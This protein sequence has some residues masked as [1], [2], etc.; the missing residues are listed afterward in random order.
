MHR[1]G[2]KL[3][4][5]RP[6]PLA[7]RYQCRRR[8]FLQQLQN[9]GLLPRHRLRDRQEVVW[10]GHHR[11]V[12]EVHQ[13]TELFLCERRFE[14]TAPGDDGEVV[15]TGACEDVEDGGGDVG[16]GEKGDE[17][18]GDVRRD[19]SVADDGHLERSY[20]GEGVPVDEGEGRDAVR[21][22]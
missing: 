14:G 5:P 1:G 21:R 19:V 18:A 3:E 17:H 11:H 12:R 22:G 7:R 16:F 2:V 10:D 15:D 8:A 6:T 9:T 4:R 20:R 13:L